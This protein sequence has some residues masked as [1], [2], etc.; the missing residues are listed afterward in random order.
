M[1]D[2][3]KPIGS[4]FT[5][6]YDSAKNAISSVG[7]SN[8]MAG[9]STSTPNPVAYTNQPG[10][11]KTQPLAPYPIPLTPNPMKNAMGNALTGL[12]QGQGATTAPVKNTNIIPNN[13][14]SI[15]TNA[16]QTPSSPSLSNAKAIIPQ[17]RP[18]SVPSSSSSSTPSYTYANPGF[19]SS[20]FAK[21]GASTYTPMEM[22]S[23][24]QLEA[25]KKFQ[26]GVT[27]LNFGSS[28]GSM[29]TGRTATGGNPLGVAQAQLGA[30]P[31]ED[32]NQQ[33]NQQK[34]PAGGVSPLGKT[35]WD[36][37]VENND[38]R[39]GAYAPAK[40]Q[41]HSPVST[42]S[43]APMKTP[44]M[45]KTFNL[46]DV[47]SA[48][49]AVDNLKASPDWNNPNDLMALR[50]SLQGLV[51]TKLKEQSAS[52]P[53]PKDPVVDTP[54]Q[55]QYIQDQPQDIQGQLREWMDNWRV[56]NGVPQLESAR[57]DTLNNITAINK[58][59][60]EA[61]DDIKSNPDLPKAL[62]LRRMDA[63][64]KQFA[65]TL[66][67]L[68]GS[69]KEITAQ[70]DMQN[71]ALNRELGIQQF[72]LEYANSQRK[73][74]YDLFSTMLSAGMEI[75][76]ENRKEWAQRLGVSEGA[77]KGIISKNSGKDV[78]S[79]QDSNG[80]QV[81]YVVGK[82]GQPVETGRLGSAKA[83]TPGNLSSSQQ[84][85]FGRITKKVDAA[86]QVANKANSLQASIDALRK[87]PT[88]GANQINSIYQYIKGLD[89]DSAVRE[90][91]ID[92]I[93]GGLQSILGKGENLVQRINSN[94]S[95]TASAALDLANGAQNLV[96][97]IYEQARANEA[98]F[99][100]EANAAGIGDT[101]NSY[102]SGFQAPWDG[103]QAQAPAEDD[104]QVMQSILT[105]EEPAT[106]EPG[107]WSTLWNNITTG[108]KDENA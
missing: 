94:Q 25:M 11:P 77:L 55:S 30:T 52:N 61:T 51:D 105:G 45:P 38:P 41:P 4:F 3:L 21:Q 58:A 31:S 108:G 79:F 49:T 66:S 23:P 96:N 68:E 98:R 88:N 7:S 89:T 6:L 2:F 13:T 102:R 57:L 63:V 37:M 95:I 81:F 47:Q 99:R 36:R 39:I 56:S 17:P 103:A 34:N 16:P 76:D 67:T 62:A 91:E 64:Q 72:G 40:I 8:L 54:E 28:S 10:L 12:S 75:T 33:F 44:S 32:E 26:A 1:F 87:N 43:E 22:W 101:W 107:F 15:I 85:V 50:D 48:Q 86:V 80:Q 27:P 9:P 83:S 20:P 69:L 60:K 74:Q 90:G 93:Q 46:S 35:M 24:A 42:R 5:D 84:S 97:N 71:Q 14:A 59:I 70:L 106:D 73:A 78:K 92:L 104:A 53:P 29:Q 82:D 18:A 19:Y 100:S 65:D